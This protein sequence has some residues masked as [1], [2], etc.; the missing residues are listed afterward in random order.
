[1]RGAT[2]FSGIGAP[3]IAAPEIEWVWHAEIDAFPSAVMTHHHG[4]PNL[5]D[6]SADDFIER[7]KQLGPIDIL[8]AGS[9]C[10][11]FSVA[12]K[13]LGL[14]DPRGNLALVTL[15]I[16]QQLKPRWL[17]FENVPGLLTSG[18]GD[19]FAAFLDQMEK[20]GYAGGW[21]VLDAQYAGVAQRRRRVFV[22]GHLGD[23]WRPSAAV[24]FEPAGLCGDTPPSRETREETAPYSGGGIDDGRVVGTVTSKWAKGTGGP[25]GD[26][27]YNL[28]C[29]GAKNSASQGLSASAD[30]TPTLSTTKV[31][32]VA[33]SP[34]AFSSKD[35][36][37]DA[38]YNLSPTL[39]AGGHDQ[40]SPNGGVPPAV[41][42]SHWD[43]A[44]NPHPTLTQTHNTGGIGASNQEI[45]SQRGG[46][47]APHL[48]VR[49]LTPRECERLQGFPEITEN[50]EIEICLAS[51][52]TA[53]ADVETPCTTEQ[54]NAYSAGESELA[55][56]VKTAEHPLSANRQ[57]PGKHAVLSVRMHLD[58]KEVEILSQGKWTS[59]ASI[60]ESHGSLAPPMQI[61]DFVQLLAR[62]P[63]G[64]GT[65]AVDG[66]EASQTTER[67]S[68]ARQN[69]KLFVELAGQ[70]T[71]EL[72]KSAGTSTTEVSQHSTRTTS[73]HMRNAS[74][75]GSTLETW[76]C[77][78]ALAICGFIPTITQ[79]ASFLSIQIE[80]VRGFTAITYRHGKPAADGPRYKALGNS[81]AVPVIGW[82]L[83][84]VRL[85]SELRPTALRAD[86]QTDRYNA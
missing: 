37:G 39:R 81:M 16:C 41:A 6:V 17:V 73:F 21:R 32:A 2:L 45:F 64:S 11:S 60:A 56:H 84:R 35:Y 31:P 26:E 1:M 51:K 83:D 53:N 86:A 52:C 43:D 77:S 3:E 80:V 76:S 44:S 85:F 34:V 8:V 79:N 13:R 23:D 5:G 24:L 22:V 58:R 15:G 4:T 12:G 55:P 30:I 57:D 54:S 36:G 47:L 66:R 25:A 67:R 49:R 69:G 20:C 14:D 71:N 27:G 10:Q 74:E 82:V 63:K 70:E 78:V 46:G 75:R 72:A 65:K 29:F 19:D 61:E 48:T 33:G 28:I 18:R 68:L 59:L 40:S 38:M 7:A 62:M 42:G 9:P 50:A